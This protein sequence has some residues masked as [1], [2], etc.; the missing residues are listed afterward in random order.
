MSY[1]TQPQF[2]FVSRKCWSQGRGRK[3]GTLLRTLPCTALC[4]FAWMLC[5]IVWEYLQEISSEL[6]ILLTYSGCKPHAH[7]IKVAAIKPCMPFSA[8]TADVVWS[9]AS[10]P[11]SPMPSFIVMQFRELSSMIP[12]YSYTFLSMALKAP[13]SLTILVISL[14]HRL[15]D[16]FR[17][18]WT[19]SWNFF[20]LK[21]ETMLKYR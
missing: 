11:S 14:F 3:K 20:I 8:F 2:E 4:E 10:Q 19:W 7:S 9:L 18:S 6:G 12:I 15:L 5:C 16:N 17:K 21:E 1:H 13:V